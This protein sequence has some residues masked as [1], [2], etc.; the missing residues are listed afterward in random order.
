MYCHLF[1]NKRRPLIVTKG[2][3]KGHYG[4]KKLAVSVKVYIFTLNY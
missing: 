3:P 4:Q 1:F 2:L